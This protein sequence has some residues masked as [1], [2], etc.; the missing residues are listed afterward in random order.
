[1]RYF[2]AGALLASVVYAQTETLTPPD[3]AEQKKLFAEIAA[4]ALEYIKHPP[5]FVCTQSTRRNVDPTGTGQHWKLADTIVEQLSYIDQKEEYKVISINGKPVN[6]SNRPTGLMSSSDFGNILSLIFDPKAQAEFSWQT[7][8]SLRG[9]RVHV[10]GYRV[11][12]ARSQ[13]TITSGKTKIAAGVYGLIYADKDTAAVLRVALVA[14]D[15]P[16]KFP[17]Q[18]VTLDLHYDFAKIGGQMYLL[19]LK[20]DQH[21]KDGKSLIWNEV[22]FRDY[23]K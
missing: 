17:V 15:I 4:N 6:N 19:P 21:S 11:P 5:N 1:M 8:D 18:G 14:T 16:A 7:W 13:Y 23:R 2:L 20:A 10:V 9:A 3:A 12:Q 22:E